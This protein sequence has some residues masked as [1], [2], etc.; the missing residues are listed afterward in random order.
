M[1]NQPIGI[2]DSGVGG[3]SIWNEIV[4]L[5]PNEPTIYLADQ[6]NVPYGTKTVEEIHE[7]SRDLITFLLQRKVKLI[8][9]ACNTITVNCLDFLREEFPQIPIIGTVPVVKLAAQVTKN[10]KIGILSTIRTAYSH[11]QKQLISTYAGE[12][13]VVNIGTDRLVPFVERGET[14]SEILLNTLKNELQPFQATH[15]DTLALGC[16][17]YP[18][19]RDEMQKILGDKISILDSGAAIARQVKR[20]LENNKLFSSQETKSYEFYTTGST[21]KF[22]KVA[23]KLVGEGIRDKIG[24]VE[25]ILC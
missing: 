16:T 21:E 15:I 22:T 9:I 24:M 12:C 10:R 23:K 25:K 19:L 8:V 20:V 3:L 4:A 11:Y 7:L 17:H 1:H 13:E 14:N 18:F 2:L 6:K 5:L